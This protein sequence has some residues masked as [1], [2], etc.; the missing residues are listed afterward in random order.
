MTSS[1]ILPNNYMID[2][3][4]TSKFA[5]LNAEEGRLLLTELAVKASAGYRNSHSEEEFLAS[6]HILRNDRSLKK[7]GK[8]FICAML[9]KHS[10]NKSDFAVYSEKYRK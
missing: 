10:N 5:H 6:F 7:Y 8:Q 9:Y 1:E 2:R 4:K 3:L